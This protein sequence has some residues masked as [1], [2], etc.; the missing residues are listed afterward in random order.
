MNIE[1]IRN[2]LYK[3]YLEDFNRFCQELGGST[4][5]VMGHILQ[6]EADRRTIN[7]TI[8]SFGTELSKDD[9]ARL[10]PEFGL[11]YPTVTLKLGKAEDID[12]VVS[13]CAPY[14]VRNLLSGLESEY[15]CS[16]KSCFCF[17][18]Q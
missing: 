9:R 4:A 15:C 2:T 6:F 14:G 12:S 17:F 8:N 7:I 3:S 18:P 13:A 10:F 11:L 1:I 5:E 16:P